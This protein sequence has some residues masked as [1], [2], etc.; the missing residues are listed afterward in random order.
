MARAKKNPGQRVVK[1]GK[2]VVASMADGFRKRLLKV[3][4]DGVKDLVIDLK[5]V[6]MIDSV[7]IGI[8]IATHNSM[9][10]T[11]GRLTLSNVSEDIHGLLKTMRLDQHFDVQ[12]VR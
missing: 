2:D 6:D 3:I 11:G 12:Q 10:N 8:I 9:S 4:K 7:G 1:P 5:G